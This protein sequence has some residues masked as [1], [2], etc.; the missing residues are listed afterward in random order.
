MSGGGKSST[1]TSSVSIPPEV[2]A[3]YNSVNARAEEVAQQ[4]FTPYG[5]QF[6]A[7]L[8]GTQQAGIANVSQAAGMAQ[9]YYQGASTALLGGAAQAQPYYQGATEALSGGQAAAAP[10]QAAAAQNIAGAQ[11][12]AQ[13]YQALATGY[14][15]AGA[16][17]VA[18]GGLNVGAY[19]SPYT[20]A[21]AQPTYQ[22]LRQQ[23]QQEQQRIIGDQIRSGAFGGDRGRI[24]QANL[25]QQQ[26]LATAQALGNIYQQ[27]YGQALGAAQQQQGVSLQAEQANR[28]AQQQAANQFLG[29][30]QQAFGQG[31]QTAQ[32]Q[33]ALAQQQFGQGVQSAQT[34]QALGQGVYGMGAGVSQGLAGIG[35]GAQQAA[36]QGGQA[37]LAAGTVE[38]QTQQAQNQA[39]YNQFLQQQGYPFQVAQFLANIAMG[40]GALSG[41]TTTTTQPSSFFSDERLKEDL[42][43]IGK[44]FDGQDIVRFK[45]KGEPGTRIGLV[46][47]DV[48]KKH[49]EAVGL[50]GGYKTV[51]Y[52]AATD[53]AAA[54]A[55]HKAYGGGLSPWEGGSM[56]GSVFR[57]DAGQG[58]AAG[59][60][61]GG[62]DVLAQI[63]ALVNS[64]Q[65]MFPYGKAGMY[66]SGMGK[67]GPYGSTLMQP[68]SRGLMRA[69][70]VGPRPVSAMEGIESTVRRAENIGKMYQGA[71]GGVEFAKEQTSL[72]PGYS[73]QAQGPTQSGGTVSDPK[74]LA[75]YL[76]SYT[77]TTI[78]GEPSTSSG[79]ARGGAIRSGLA[80][81]GLPYSQATD[82]YVPED[83]S[84][85]F[86]PG[87]LE[88]AKPP[89]QQSSSG[90]DLM[91]F[92]KL[93]AA[94]YGAGASTGGAI[95]RHYEYG[96]GLS[97]DYDAPS[98]GSD[99]MPDQ[100]TAPP[101]AG[102]APDPRPA[103]I[104]EDDKKDNQQKVQ[105]AQVSPGVMQPN[106]V[107]TK[108]QAAED[109]QKAA[110]LV[111]LAAAA[112]FSDRRLKDNIEPIGKLFDGQ[113]VYRYNFKGDDKKQIGL[114][115]QEV[116]K[117]YPDAVGLAPRK[118]YQPG[119]GVTAPE[120]GLTL[121]EGY[122]D[123]LSGRESSGRPDATNLLFPPER[124]GPVGQHQFT[125]R[126]FLNMARNDPRYEGKS[127]AE[128]LADRNNPTVSAVYADRYARENAPVLQ[129]AGFDPTRENLALAHMQGPTGATALL[130][131]P[132]RS[133]VDVLTDVYGSR[134][135]AMT[136]L[137][138]NRG[139]PN[140]T[141]AQFVARLTG[142]PQPGGLGIVSPQDRQTAGL[143]PRTQTLQSREPD[144]LDRNQSWLVPLLTGLGTMASSPSR[145]LG[146]AIL[147]GLAG[148]AQSYAG[149]GLREQEMALR[150]GQLAETQQTRELEG[151]RIGLQ[152]R[153][154]GLQAWAAFLQRHQRTA[155][156]NTG[157]SGW[158]TE[159]GEFITNEEFAR[160][161]DRILRE[162]GLNL[163]DISRPSAD[164]S[165]AGGGQ[166]RVGPPAGGPGTTAP[167]ERTGT[168]PPSGGATTEPAGA[169]RE[170]AAAG[171]PA[172]P[173]ARPPGDVVPAQAP[174][175][176]P[177]DAMP[178]QA[179]ENQQSVDAR[180]NRIKELD[181]I[182]Q[183]QTRHVQRLADVASPEA[184][185][186]QSILQ[187][188][189][190]EKHELEGQEQSTASGVR[191]VIR[192][193]YVEDHRPPAP[194]T[195][196][197]RAEIDPVTG[198]ISRAPVDVG[199]RGTG[200][201]ATPND[202]PMNNVQITRAPMIDRARESSG[203]AADEFL[204]QSGRSEDAVQNMFRFATALKILEAGGTTMQRAEISNL[205]RGLGLGRI[206]DTVQD[207]RDTNAA[208][209]AAKTGIMNAIEV[210]SQAFPRMTQ[211]EFGTLVSR[212]VPSADM[213]PDAVREIMRGQLAASMF[214]A[215]F[216]RDWTAAQEQGVENFN[217]FSE[218]W[219][220]QHPPGLFMDSADRL[221][222]NLRGQGLPSVDKLTEGVVYVMPR[223]TRNRAL[224]EQEKAI[225][226]QFGIGPGELFVVRN[227]NQVD[228]RLEFD[229]QKIPSDPDAFSIYRQAPALR[230]YGER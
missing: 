166:E 180:A 139:D 214:T 172:A 190:R 121:P 171:Q 162:F 47:Q 186:Q 137:A 185:M 208:F 130:S 228:G 18:P 63:N 226:R 215:Q 189:I 57:E 131:N 105:S 27:G 84:K 177:M 48:E 207:S 178:V 108:D 60:A 100:D 22:A 68:Q 126:T 168:P 192:P 51:D 45:Y 145:Y 116:E 99:M 193:G 15:L 40:T 202:V 31:S 143:L 77:G 158:R 91:Q 90:Q 56:G 85:P 81:G 53:E 138:Q 184:P 117:R 199:Y 103:S 12:G 8:T 203:R 69:E 218:R 20:E 71:K 50:S 29:I 220:R 88:T 157:Q 112:F 173:G 111:A 89:G 82:E 94:A 194:V 114:M 170:P 11:A 37:Q 93:A 9:P 41:S 221:L 66:G 176:V 67:A 97:P 198:Q 125:A 32:Q 153:Q 87:K 119:G 161:Q 163:S 78:F 205:M 92:A 24:A 142:S 44:T 227:L 140:M 76:H 165:P 144:F 106:V 46:A 54:R 2:L 64:H 23:Q 104:L 75:D 133:A 98:M 159:T 83:V 95:R 212:A 195:Q 59:G 55:P 58:F 160:R 175:F 209:L 206:A 182:I 72:S 43:P 230:M 35:T 70:N 191:Y 187:N 42:E 167:G 204:A 219:R 124:G 86:T 3:R 102:L 115:A 38:Q 164:V 79:V 123:F 19:M 179:R 17:Q 136:V 7:P 146:S 16:R 39:L 224:S 6:V 49:P 211:N 118:G 5:G 217:A 225:S 113:K 36:L 149:L 132:E 152:E 110:Q 33:A 181:A 62:D 109:A 25:A 4:P 61:P 120:T 150:R 188:A 223:E 134:D 135:R 30:G 101:Y 148:G 13:P 216:R 151:R 80:V 222:G 183:R 213:P 96:G 156:P 169:P 107:A 14:G 65:G 21:V 129:R 210:G 127:E 229:A 73:S 10:L 52:D 28:Q 74:T 174:Q 1:S 200:G 128:I 26:N 155:D 147:Q 201:F 154:A 34:Q 196:S 141:S 122:L 197:P